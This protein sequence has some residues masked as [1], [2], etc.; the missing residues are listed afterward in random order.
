[1]DFMNKK[2]KNGVLVYIKSPETG[3]VKSR[4]SASIDDETVVKIYK[5]FVQDILQ[6]LEKIPDE[7][8]TMY[9]WWILSDRFFK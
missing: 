2:E 5:L 1:M 6:K 8:R 9:R 3:K 7:N 4:L